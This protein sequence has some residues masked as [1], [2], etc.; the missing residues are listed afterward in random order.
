MQ[1]RAHMNTTQLREFDANKRAHNKAPC[2]AHIQTCTNSCT[3]IFIMYVCY[4]TQMY[5]KTYV[6][7]YTYTYTTI[8][9]PPYNDWSIS[10]FHLL[11]TSW[12][13]PHFIP[14][15]AFIKRTSRHTSTR[16]IGH[17]FSF[18]NFIIP[19]NSDIVCDIHW[20]LFNR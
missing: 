8:R 14:S 2:T 7:I 10:S 17:T 9:V 3:R 11:V 5:T 20:I 1:N 16:H 6:A 4:D 19:L 18:F 15:L 13:S 12:V